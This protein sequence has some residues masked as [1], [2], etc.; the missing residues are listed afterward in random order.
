MLVEAGGDPLPFFNI[1][2]IAPLLLNSVYDWKYV[3]VPQENAC[4]ALHNNQSI[5][6]A[7]KILGGSSRLNY[8]VYVK[9]HFED[10]D[11]W[12]PDFKGENLLLYK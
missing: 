4:K 9:G 10:Y 12:F 3:T 2:L 1:P 11:S 6:S 7:G 8:M 5:W